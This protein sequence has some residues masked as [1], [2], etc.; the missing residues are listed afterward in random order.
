MNPTESIKKLMLLSSQSTPYCG[1][2]WQKSS[3]RMV[4]LV[5]LW[6]FH[7]KYS[8]VYKASKSLDKQQLCRTASQLTAGIH[9]YLYCSLTRVYIVFICSISKTCSFFFFFL[10]QNLTPTLKLT[11][12]NYSTL[13]YINI[14]FK[15][16]CW[17]K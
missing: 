2:N 12:L 4:I 11:I 17:C 10:L 1:V 3:K 16:K 7:F 6:K 9:R 15:Q 5:L 14:I 13:Q 8:K